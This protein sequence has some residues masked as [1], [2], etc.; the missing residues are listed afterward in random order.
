[1]NLASL[2]HGGTKENKKPALDGLWCS[3]VRNCSL[4]ELT[5]YVESTPNIMKKVVP[6][7]KNRIKKFE[8]SDANAA[9]SLK[10]LYSGGLISKKKYKRMRS[11][12]ALNSNLAKTNYA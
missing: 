10:F 12:G 3:L 8:K 1:M 6:P 7:I 11:D 5:K 4:G 9:R 2:I